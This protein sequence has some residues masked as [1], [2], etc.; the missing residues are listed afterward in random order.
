MSLKVGSEFGAPKRVAKSL[1]E[2]GQRKLPGSVYK[3]SYSF[4]FTVYGGVLRG[5]YLRKVVD[6]WARRSAQALTRSSR[7]FRAMRY[8]LVGSNGLEVSHD[9]VKTVVEAGVPGDIVECGVA[10]GGC[11]G[12]MGL[13]MLD[14]PA[15]LNR[16]LW[17]FDSFEGLPPPTSA[18]VDPIIGSTGAHVRPLSKGACLGSVEDVSYV[19]FEYFSMPEPR[20]RLVKG[21]FEDTL[22]PARSEL[23]EI[24]VLRIDGDWYESTRTCLSALY[25]RVSPGGFVIVDDYDS[26]YGAKRA[27]DEFIDAL[28]PSGRPAALLPDGRG[29]RFFRK[30]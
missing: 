8:S 30:A 9:L 27:T 3:A 24:G 28:P 6:S 23:T 12:L 29:G 2:I 25:D 15:A 22:I 17:L 18:D 11:A 16:R 5:W 21:W 7:V 4:V 14:D 1:L 13:A 10:R 19:I 20:V 26:C